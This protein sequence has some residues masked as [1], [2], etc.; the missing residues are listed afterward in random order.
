MLWFILGMSV[1]W[2]VGLLTASLMFAAKYAD[3]KQ[4]KKEEKN[5]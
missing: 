1:E 3:E 2:M 4:Q 5:G